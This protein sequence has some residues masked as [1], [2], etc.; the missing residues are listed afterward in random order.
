[1][2]KME[3]NKKKKPPSCLKEIDTYQQGGFGQFTLLRTPRDRD[4]VTFAGDKLLCADL[5]VFM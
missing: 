3:K 4:D 1:M 2:I 5:A